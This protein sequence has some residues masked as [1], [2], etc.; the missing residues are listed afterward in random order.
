MQ[1]KRYLSEN[2]DMGKKYGYYCFENLYKRT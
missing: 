2:S 1:N